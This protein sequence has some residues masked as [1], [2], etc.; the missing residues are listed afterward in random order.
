MQDDFLDR[1][2]R[3]QLDCWSELHR[4]EFWTHVREHGF[5]RDLYVA[6]MTEIFH[7]TRHNAQNQALAAIRLSSDRLDLLRFCLHHAYD[8]AGHDLMV[9]HDLESIGVD[10]ADVLASR[11]LPE[12]EAFIGYLYRVASTRDATARLGYSYWAE[13][14]YPHIAELIEGMRRGL[15][16]KDA[17]MTFFIAHEAIDKKHYREVQD[18]ARKTCT[19][20][21]LQDGF[22]EVMVGTLHLQGRM[23]E[24][25]WRAYRAGRAA[26][27]ERELVTS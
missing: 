10:R 26:R 27:G 21:E 23:L 6:F 19:T 3:R 1:C 13:G 22:Q 4:G 24:G 11:P 25:V 17:Q 15:G 2:D 12:T 18:L 14:C 7:Y 5:D 20:K 9:L 8:E 16:L